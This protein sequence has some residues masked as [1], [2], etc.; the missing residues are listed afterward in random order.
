MV[1]TSE[2]ELIK[3][4]RFIATG[5]I[6]DADH[7]ALADACQQLLR[8]EIQRSPK[9]A[10]SLAGKLVRQ[11]RA[12]GGVLL[13][14]GLLVYGLALHARG[15][16]EDAKNQILEARGMV[17][18][19][20]AIRARVDRILIDVYMYLG[21]FKEATKR[22]RSASAAFKRADLK[23]EVAKT[24]VNYANLLHRQDRHLEA[25]RQYRKAIEGLKETPDKISLSICRYN[26]ANT[27]VQA[28]DFAGASKLYL[29]AEKAFDSIG[30]ELYAN[31]SRYGT[32]WLRMLRGDYHG[33]LAG[34]AE[35]EAVYERA[36]Q[37]K[38]AMLCQLD[39]AETYLALHLFT[40]ARN[41]ARTAEQAA[42]RLGLK[43]EASK[44][45]LFLARAAL[46]VGDRALARRATRRAEQGFGDEKNQAFLG[47]VSLMQALSDSDRV[48]GRAAIQRARK[49]FA[50]AQL[51]L[52][53]AI[54][55]LEYLSLNPSDMAARRRLSRNR[56]VKSVPH[57]YAAW[58][59]MLGDRLKEAGRLAAARSHWARAAQMLE[60][61]R[62]KLPPI[63]ARSLLS[64][65][66]NDPYLRL[67]DSFGGRRP[68]EAAVWLERHRTAGLWAPL[69]T[70][71]GDTD[72]RDDARKSLSDLANEVTNLSARIGDKSSRAPV[73]EIRHTARIERLQ[74][75]VRRQ[76]LRLEVG[77][78]RQTADHRELATAFQDVSR[79]LPVVQFHRES[80][81]LI[82]LVHHGGQTKLKRYESGCRV[83][84]DH[85][86]LWQ[87]LLSRIVHTK[88]KPSRTDREDERRLFRALGEWLWE[89]LA[90]HA[91]S[92]RMLIL[93]EGE[94][95][96]LPWCA[97]EV[98]G[99]ALVETI[100]LVVAPSLRH[101]V[102]AGQVEES[103]RKI[104]VFA[105]H[106]EGLAYCREELSIFQRVPGW[107]VTIYDKCKRE[108]WPYQGTSAIWHYLGHARFRVDNPFYSTLQL[109][110]GPLFAADLRLRHNR[111]GLVTLAACRT[112]QQV[113]TP[114]EES[115][116]LV[117]S[118]LEMGA[119]N[120]IASHWSVSD[121]STALWM[122][123]FYEAYLN[124]LTLDKCMQQAAQAVRERFPSAY[125][126]AAFS[127]FGAGK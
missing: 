123:T 124:D 10:T 31:E 30:Y 90:E 89:P 28:L 72:S 21:D 14:T 22:F 91:S 62:V 84:R 55:D 20:P 93:P 16:Y 70:R 8:R 99:R 113:F 63:E 51:P 7:R 111:V 110:D 40:D 69:E 17:V 104:E 12:H 126:W 73:D 56:A 79:D 76:M 66:G 46:A 36:G 87:V 121:E 15:S 34:L 4:R 37:A 49:L 67:V 120:V 1:A 94:L 115:S 11:A 74:R 97:L 26:L 45:A 32:A 3:A 24:R 57:L 117:R 96:N 44:A 116:G 35:C 83:L 13:E 105:G 75:Q 80:E 77:A 85:V 2:K 88:G 43:Y 27:L 103:S 60:A 52:W 118:L 78:D 41:A 47:V 109:A 6:G 101:Y 19:R 61:V 42:R 53:E 65:R 86:G 48:P 39:R 59:T 29:Q 108:D 23:H 100:G 18:R 68:A 119:R 25:S 102:R 71:R 81:D 107:D 127:L 122:R 92:G 33:A 82:A 58:H 114:G 64:H 95:W 106:T 112:G 50:K 5:E 54:S 38:G 125:H 98:N 9:S